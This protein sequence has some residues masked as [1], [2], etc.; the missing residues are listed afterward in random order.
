MLK[1]CK[2]KIEGYYFRFENIVLSSSYNPIKDSK[3]LF[4]KLEEQYNNKDY[5][6]FTSIIPVYHIEYFLK[7]PDKKYFFLY[8]FPQIEINDILLDFVK[9]NLISRD[10]YNVIS[11]NLYTL[12]GFVN[13]LENEEI[14]I[15]KLLFVDYPIINNYFEKDYLNFKNLI[16]ESL[17]SKV[18]LNTTAN[19]FDNIWTDNVIKNI[20]Y[21]KNINFISKIQNSNT[22][23]VLIS[24]GINTEKNIDEIRKASKHYPTFIIPGIYNLL[25]KSNVQVDFVI[26]TDSSFYN[27]YHHF[28][29]P[30]DIKLI[31]P[32]S[33]NNNIVNHFVNKFFF[34]QNSDFEIR[35]LQNIKYQ[36]DKYMSLMNDNFFPMSGTVVNTALKI[37]EF[38][39]FK[40]IVVYG[41]DFSITPFK[42]HSSSNITEEIYFNSCSKL[43]TFD[44]KL[45]EIS[46]DIVKNKN[47]YST[48]KLLLYKSLYD[49]NIKSLNAVISTG[50]EDGD[51]WDNKKT[52][53]LGSVNLKKI[54]IK[55]I[56]KRR[57]LII[58][59]NKNI[60]K[61]LI[62]ILN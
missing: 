20:T 55:Y 45:S 18:K 21:S 9:K 44:S 10:V 31:C 56:K 40:E 22:T 8:I 61:K 14:E 32:M 29:I 27:Y 60:K 6:V 50:I 58:E 46:G 17:D 42:T 30:S 25:S 28:D 15:N 53:D 47:E 12:N 16:K 51:L 23:A 26:T 13:L 37:L 19:Y 49:K 52:I 39:G 38:F 2:A 33:V 57:K 5:I 7:N 59:N 4:L 54:M 41:L 62:K 48:K 3:K 36:D 1:I 34:F 24:S 35:L 11:N 43:N